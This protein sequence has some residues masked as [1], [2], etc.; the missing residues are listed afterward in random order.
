MTYHMGVIIRLKKKKSKWPLAAILD[1]THFKKTSEVK[2]KLIQQILKVDILGY[3]NQSLK[4]I[5]TKFPGLAEKSC[6]AI[7]NYFFTIQ[8]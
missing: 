2:P 5:D 4:T 8:S 6:L 3:K 1:F 7:R